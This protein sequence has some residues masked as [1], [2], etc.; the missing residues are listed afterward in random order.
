MKKLIG[1]RTIKTSLA[2][3][4]SV[5]ISQL[6]EDSLP[7]YSGI[8]AIVSMG[9]T[10]KSTL[11][12]MKS[13]MLGTLCG[14]IVGIGLSY[15]DRGNILLCGIGII[16][17]IIICN[18]LK[19]SSSIPIS[20]IVLLG[21]MISTSNTPLYYGVHRLIDTFIGLSVAYLLNRYFFPYTNEKRINN[22]DTLL[23]EKMDE[24]ITLLKENQEIN[25]SKLENDMKK[26]QNELNLFESDVITDSQKNLIDQLEKKYSVADRILFEMKNLTFIN[27][28][29]NPMIY[30]Y[31]HQ[32]ALMIYDQ[33]K[34]NEA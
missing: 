17:L 21:I 13:R 19:I 22:L 18:Q 30:H 34:N 4:I 14:A 1:L 6:F 10:A 28:S 27:K 11:K 26:I 12:V 16:L 25:L 5:M 20:G 23:R 8:A 2:V 32:E 9:K 7:F 3:M 33:Y 31:H 29:E 24:M 15:I